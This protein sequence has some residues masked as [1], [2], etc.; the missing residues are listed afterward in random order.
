MMQPG[1]V[2]EGTPL[3]KFTLALQTNVATAYCHSIVTNIIY[4]MWRNNS[5]DSQ[6]HLC[7]VL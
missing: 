6:R 2:E 7:I 5:V 1:E 4:T 3:S